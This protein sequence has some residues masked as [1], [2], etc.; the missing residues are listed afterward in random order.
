MGNIRFKCRLCDQPLSIE[1]DAA[2]LDIA[3]PACGAEQ[4]VPSPSVSPHLA[5]VETVEAP[6]PPPPPPD[7]PVPAPPPSPP[8]VAP[9]AND[10]KHY[11]AFISY[12]S[13]DKT[14]ARWL[15]QAIETYGLPAELAGRHA[16]P[17]GPAAPK[18]FRP[19]FRDRDEL[20]ASADLGAVIKQAISDSRYLIVICSPNAARS[21]WVNTEIE[22]FISINGR[23]RV[24][25]IIVEGEPNAGDE[26]ECFPPALRSFEPIAADARKHADGKGNAKLKLLAGM[27]GVRFDM[28][29]QRDAVRR[30]KQFTLAASVGG[31]VVAV[32]VG[33]AGFALSQRGAA[34]SERSRGDL[35]KYAADMIA[36]QK[37]WE[38]GD[39]TRF[40]SLLA[41][42]SP[43][44]MAGWEWHYWR[45]RAQGG[46][47]VIPDV[48]EGG[49]EMV[50]AFSPDGKR[51][52]VGGYFDDSVIHVVDART[53]R[54][55]LKLHGHDSPPTFLRYSRDGR[56]IASA[57]E[58]N[59]VRFWDAATG[60]E[61][62]SR[63]I[64]TGG[65]YSL[66]FSPDG[67]LLATS[68]E[69]GPGRVWEVETGRE[70]RKFERRGEDAEDIATDYVCFSPNS[71]NVVLI[72]DGDH[73]EVWSA[74]RGRRI[75]DITMKR[76]VA[77]YFNL[78]NCVTVSPDGSLL[79]SGSENGRIG[80]WDAKT[81]A[82]QR[83]IDAHTR[84][85]RSLSFS[86]DGQTLLSG[87]TD[88][89]VKMWK[90]GRGTAIPSN[91]TCE[92]Q[93]KQVA[94]S[95]DGQ[96]VAAGDEFGIVR[97]WPVAVEGAN[98]LK[99]VGAG[100]VCLS[101]DGKY[102]VAV[103][104]GVLR[105]QETGDAAM[106]REIR[107]EGSIGRVFFSPDGG[108]MLHLPNQGPGGVQSGCD[109]AGHRPFPGGGVGHRH[110]Q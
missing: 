86:P 22:N 91:W 44:G 55:L 14:W 18:R 104:P 29:K 25:A 73:L 49:G 33:L 9:V 75:L 67:S 102:A 109:G 50:L 72:T 16:T 39:M 23:D 78:M 71:R 89:T 96:C 84:G 8:P 45:M 98:V 31:A 108:R 61:E 53:G 43:R 36:M 77:N 105:L 87:G 103:E 3:C 32:V 62:R 70:L 26:R 85:V 60:V 30:R 100:P 59:T 95:P 5:R 58:D 80:L 51:L 106:V 57:S 17:A 68:N 11:W 12:S 107:Y 63:R 1:E 42:G 20:P 34:R 52:A 38:Q 76:E 79:A 4:P 2:G 41:A 92:D 69:S 110:R 81:G 90:V 74:D 97:I 7:R 99:Q 46:G 35:R 40:A 37:A 64:R 83:S 24:F 6:V 27:L 13:K 48:S 65:V 28:L 66:D 15:H 10:N 56:R 54:E 19:V 47:L 88:K 94:F 101:P 93:I 82:W 21:V